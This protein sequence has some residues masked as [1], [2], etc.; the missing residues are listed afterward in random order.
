MVSYPNNCIIFIVCGDLYISFC[1]RTAFINLSLKQ[2]AI[3]V[4]VSSKNFILT[5][6]VYIM[7]LIICYLLYTI[8]ITCSL[9]NS[10]QFLNK[11]K[12]MVL[13]LC[14]D[15]KLRN[16]ILVLRCPIGFM[17]ILQF[18]SRTPI[19]TL[20]WPS[21]DDLISPHFAQTCGICKPVSPS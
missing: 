19:V 14:T 9:N 12:N 1:L 18:I 6:C 13:V 20:A 15:W 8:I 3:V 17:F 21:A 11:I 10:I 16:E 2:P 7:R 4:E 5:L